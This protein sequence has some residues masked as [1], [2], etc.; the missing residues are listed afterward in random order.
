MLCCAGA[1]ALLAPPVSLIAPESLNCKLHTSCKFI[2]LP[3][4]SSL[5]F[6]LPTCL[7]CSAL[8][9]SRCR[10]MCWWLRAPWP[11]WQPAQPPSP[12]RCTTHDVSF[13]MCRFTRCVVLPDG[14]HSIAVR[15]VLAPTSPPASTGPATWC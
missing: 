12:W 13:T 8:E 11:A 2:V 3:D 5:F 4:S 1:N 10:R 6:T 9:M 7:S 15:A 14:L